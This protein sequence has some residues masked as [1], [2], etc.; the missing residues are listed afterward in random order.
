M[1]YLSQ[2]NHKYLSNPQKLI[3]FNGVKPST[4][5]DTNPFIIYSTDVTTSLRWKIFDIVPYV[6]PLTRTTT[7]SNDVIISADDLKNTTQFTLVDTLIESDWSMLLCNF[8]LTFTCSNFNNISNDS[9]VFTISVDDSS[10]TKEFPLERQFVNT[11]QVYDYLK[12]NQG[13]HFTISATSTKE[14]SYLPVQRIKFNDATE[15]LSIATCK[16]IYM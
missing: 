7:T 10:V 8:G 15:P 5:D 12:V 6:T 9:I 3:N 2:N 4:A 1:N 13:S 11:F 16:V 14:L